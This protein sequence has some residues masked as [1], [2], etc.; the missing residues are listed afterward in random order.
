[1]SHKRAKRVA[2][3]SMMLTANRLPPDWIGGPDAWA[4]GKSLVGTVGSSPSSDEAPFGFP[5][6]SKKR[7]KETNGSQVSSFGLEVELNLDLLGLLG[8]LA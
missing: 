4:H 8:T 7:S 2:D 6:K 5:Q 3:S 1:M